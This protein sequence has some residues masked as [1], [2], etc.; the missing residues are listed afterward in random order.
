MNIDADTLSRLHTSEDS[1]KTVSSQVVRALMDSAEHQVPWFEVMSCN[2][3]ISEEPEGSGLN[4]ISGEELAAA[5]QEDPILLEVKY[6]LSGSVTQPQ[7]E[8]SDAKK[9][10]K[11]NIVLKNVVLYRDRQLDG[12][13]SLQIVLPRS[14]QPVALTGCHG[15]AGH[16]GCEK[17]ISLLQERF[18]WLGMRKDAE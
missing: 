15:T 16:L 8:S 10:L 14:L 9:L 3:N 4:I 1:S 2:A 6:I 17:T 7:T 12:E 18:F 13:Q 11:K 5:Q